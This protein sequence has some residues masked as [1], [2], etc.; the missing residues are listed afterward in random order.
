MTGVSIYSIQIYKSRNYIVNNSKVTRVA[1]FVVLLLLVVFSA[2]GDYWSYRAWY[3]S[4]IEY[5]H[6]EPIWETIRSIIPWGFDVFKLVLWG[7]CL[8]L[9]TIMC[10]LHKSDLLISFSLF[11]LFYIGNYSYARA[12]IAY[13]LV[14]FAY[15]L[16]VVAKSVR[17]LHL[18]LLLL[19]VAL[20]VWIGFQMHRSMLILLAM[21][22]ISLL[23]KPRKRIIKN[24]LLF[25]PLISIIFNTILYPYIVSFVSNDDDISRLMEVY[26]IEDTRG[27]YYFI[28]QIIEHLPILLLFFVSLKNIYK[29]DKISIIAKKI[30]FLAFL[31][32]YFAFVFYTIREGNGLALFYRTINMAYPFMI[33]TIA[34]S[35]KYLNNMYNLTLILVVYRVLLTFLVMAQVLI[36]PEYLYN[37]V[38]ERYIMF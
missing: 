18:P 13:M 32:V 19:V 38:Y 9:F 3:E 7:G 16:I 14:L 6:F 36:N 2:T 21:M 35:M 27:I 28:R 29:K 33:L 25:F 5:L 30:A 37:Q 23:L 11:A 15:Y 31:I 34:Y 12:S 17:L 24:L 26:I 8:L 20:C 1:L 10:K 22:A 4:E